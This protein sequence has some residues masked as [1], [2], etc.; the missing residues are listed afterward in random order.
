MINLLPPDERHQLRAARANTLLLRYN[1]FLV[2]I[3][4]FVLVSLVVVYFYLN[5]TRQSALAL[6]ADNDAH[7]ASYAKTTSEADTFRNS[8]AQAKSILDQE[9]TYSKTI[10][11]LAHQ[12]PSGVVLDTLDLDA[13]TFGTPT[14]L[15]LKARD[16]NSMLAAKD[17]FNKSPLFSNVHFLSLTTSNDATYPVSANLAITISKDAA[18]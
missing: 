1:I 17:A 14:T 5:N 3:L 18:K 6:K 12:M 16:Q 13:T 11:A 4:A 7:V 8:L 2:C 15:A 10:L 9:V